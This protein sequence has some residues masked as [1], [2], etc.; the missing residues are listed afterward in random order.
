MGS[1]KTILDLYKEKHNSEPLLIRS[2]GRVNIIGEH[3]D[4]NLG[5]V[6]PAAIN[7]YIF[8]AIG[9]RIDDEINIYAADY[10]DSYSGTLSSL[11]KAWKLWPNY[12]LGVINEIK[13]DGKNLSGVNI[14][15]GGDIPL[16]V[17]LS[18]S[19]AITCAAAFALNQLFALGYS[20]LELAKIGQMSEHNFVGVNCGLMDQYVSLFGKEGHLLKLNCRTNEHQYIPYPENNIE[21][22][23]F[24][25]NVKHHLVSS[26]Y[27]ERREECQKGLD[28]VKAQVPGVTALPDITE[29]MLNKYVKP[30]DEIAYKRCL[31]VIQEIDRLEKV[32]KDLESEDFEALGQRLFETHNGLQNLFEVSCDEC[33]FLVETVKQDL[34]VLGA[35]MMGGGFGGCTINLIYKEAVE[36]VTEKLRNEYKAKFNKD[37]KVYTATIGNGTEEV[38]I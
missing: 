1:L 26:A 8:I 16:A 32:C 13:K 5:S 38:K 31:Y 12:I 24:D 25:S 19:A 9:K 23:L 20:K 3:T 35:R 21:I 34:N 14:V 36:Q 30:V 6:L 2:P 11:E 15:F 17:G 4:Y 18:S 22:V 28:L 27:N 7:K 33:D 37:L 10:T 29:E